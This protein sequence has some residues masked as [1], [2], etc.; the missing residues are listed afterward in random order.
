VD[1]VSEV[2]EVSHVGDV[3]IFAEAWPGND[4]TTNGPEIPCGSGASC[5]ASTE[6]CCKGAGKCNAVTETSPEDCN[7]NRQYCYDY[8][9]C[10]DGAVCCGA[11]EGTTLG[12]VW[13]TADC[14][15]SSEF[16]VCT[17]RDGSCPSGKKCVMP[18]EVAE[19]GTRI[20]L[21]LCPK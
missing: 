4:A 9:D 13:C 10:K 21:W 1:T 8:R 12:L 3:L 19:K 2:E 18:T 5:K 20:S 7:G 17:D 15:P 14:N 6:Y 16:E 11:Q